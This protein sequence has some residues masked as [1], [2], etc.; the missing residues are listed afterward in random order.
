MVS[1]DA[2]C[3]LAGAL[4]SIGKQPKDA[5]EAYR[6]IDETWQFINEPAKCPCGRDHRKILDKR[7]R[8][9]IALVIVWLNDNHKWTR[10]QI[11]D[12]VAAVEPAEEVEPKL[13]NGVL[14]VMTEE[15]WL[16]FHNQH[17]PPRYD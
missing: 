14:I 3:A 13:S 9:S 16:C 10:T 7:L 11:A 15:Q 4:Q 6:I 17:W 12:W 1:P 2:P 8:I 5:R